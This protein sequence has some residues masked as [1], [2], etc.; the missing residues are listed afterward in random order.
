[1]WDHRSRARRFQGHVAGALNRPFVVLLDQDGSDEAHDR[2]LVGKD[3]DDSVRR[4]ISPLSRP[5][6]LQLGTMLRRE[7]HVNEHVGLSLV[8]KGGEVAETGIS[9]TL[10]CRPRPSWRGTL[11]GFA[12][13]RWWASACAFLAPNVACGCAQAEAAAIGHLGSKFGRATSISNVDSSMVS[14]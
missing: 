13:L 14:T 3:A 6:G 11:A 4:L 10:A 1:M 5:M 7:G 8:Q 12:D 2:V 9:W